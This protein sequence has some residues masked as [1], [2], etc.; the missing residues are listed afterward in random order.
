MKQTVQLLCFKWC[1]LLIPIYLNLNIQELRGDIPVS[2]LGSY[3]PVYIV[4]NWC[5]KACQFLKFFF[6]RLKKSRS[7]IISFKLQWPSGDMTPHLPLSKPA[8]QPSF[9]VFV[10]GIFDF[11]AWRLETSA[12]TWTLLSPCEPSTHGDFHL[13]Y[14]LHLDLVSCFTIPSSVQ[15]LK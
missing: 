5:P 4:I 13:A 8:S 7:I 2:S 12:W 10:D 3:F 6:L 1:L 11:Q 9:L 14:V 15:V